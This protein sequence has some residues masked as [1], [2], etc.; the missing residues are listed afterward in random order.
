M[1]VLRRKR[2]M[3]CLP[4]LVLLLSSAGVF[5]GGVWVSE[6]RAMLFAPPAADRVFTQEELPAELQ[7]RLAPSPAARGGNLAPDLRNADEA[8]RTA[9]DSH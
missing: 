6:K 5:Y 7:E 1:K 3:I 4:L 2:R 8:L 9:R